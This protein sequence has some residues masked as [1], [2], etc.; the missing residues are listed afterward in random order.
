MK[1]LESVSLA[2]I[3]AVSQDI[4]I[5][6]AVFVGSVI[7]F[8]VLQYILLSRFA[9]LATTT[10]STWDDAA[11][12][13]LEKV[14]PSTYYV[15]AFFIS[16]QFLD[17]S[18]SMQKVFVMLLALVA[19]YYV[20]QFIGVLAAHV[21][22]HLSR[23]VV[24]DQYHARAMIGL[25]LT[26][27]KALVWIGSI[28]FII[29]NFGVDVTSLIAGLGIGGIAI[30]LA[31]QGILKDLFSSFS[32]F[33]DKPFTLGDFIDIGEYSGTVQK[34]GIKT[35]RL[36]ALSGEEVIVSNQDLTS[37]KVRNFRRMEKRRVVQKIGVTYETSEE[38]LRRIP[39]MIEEVVSGVENVHFGRAHLYTFDDS[40]LTFEIV[41]FVDS[42]DYRIYMDVRESINLGI[43]RA[44]AQEGIDI[45]YPTRMVYHKSCD[46]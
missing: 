34:I 23:G 36:K 39:V 16:A 15:L 9:R 6:G 21:M 17:L 22:Q 35:T 11:I 44:F 14:R 40:A 45:A 3:P 25:I 37:A 1:S 38:S 43:I 31:L 30:A 46:K 13:A 26:I 10:Q 32:I 24:G 2:Y 33:F 5:A 27:V 28:L 12:S 19:T 7:F 4:F 41:Y 18:D 29:S 20:V 8:K 42:R